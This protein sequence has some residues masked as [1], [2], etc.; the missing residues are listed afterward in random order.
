[1][2]EYLNLEDLLSLCRDLGDLVVR[3]L[4]LLHSAAERPATSLYGTEVYPTIHEKAAA[5]LQSLTGNHALIDGN[6]RLGWLSTVVFYGLNG[7]ELDAPDD[8]AYDLVINVSTGEV[9]VREVAAV[10]G[11]WVRPIAAS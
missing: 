9:D 4:G 2:T 10:L 6:K 7:L 1:V 5:L 11:G 3:D 8:G